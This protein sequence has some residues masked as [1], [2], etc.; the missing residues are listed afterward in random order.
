MVTPSDRLPNYDRLLTGLGR[1][2]VVSA[3]SKPLDRS[4]LPT[5]SAHTAMILVHRVLFYNKRRVTDRYVMQPAC[6]FINALLVRL[7]HQLQTPF[8]TST[9][10]DHP[11]HWRC[12][13]GW[14]FE[15]LSSRSSRL[16]QCAT[17]PNFINRVAFGMMRDRWQGDSSP[18]PSSSESGHTDDAYVPSTSQSSSSHTQSS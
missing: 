1:A 16:E 9:A 15:E 3:G 7:S 11:S 5:A 12:R 6:L 17:E 8:T 2:D 13:H 18:S 14:W 4:Q 10:F